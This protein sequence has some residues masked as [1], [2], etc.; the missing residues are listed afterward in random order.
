MAPDSRNSLESHAQLIVTSLPFPS[1]PCMAIQGEEGEYGIAPGHDL[2]AAAVQCELLHPQLNCTEIAERKMAILIELQDSLCEQY[3]KDPDDVEEIY[4]IYTT[5]FRNY[6]TLYPSSQSK[7]L[8]FWPMHHIAAD[9]TVNQQSLNHLKAM[10]DMMMESTEAAETTENTENTE[11]MENTDPQ[12]LKTSEQAKVNILLSSYR[13]TIFAYAR[14][15]FTMDRAD[16][17]NES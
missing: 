15:A 5:S 14:T 10:N 12:P 13:D 7:D 9:D 3:K 2:L 8:R 16:E 6:L 4:K 1:L 17:T 11:N